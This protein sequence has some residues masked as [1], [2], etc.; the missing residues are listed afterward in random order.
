[1]TDV[2]TDISI[3]QRL[4]DLERKQAA[5]DRGAELLAALPAPPPLSPFSRYVT[6][7]QNERIRERHE[8]AQREGQERE[9]AAEREAER[10][11]A[12]L[13]SVQ[14][15]L[16]DLD[17]KIAVADKRI[18]EQ[19]RTLDALRLERERL[20]TPPPEEEAAKPV[21]G[22]KA[23]LGA[24]FGT[25]LFGGSV[26]AEHPPFKRATAAELADLPNG[27]PLPPGADDGWVQGQRIVKTKGRSR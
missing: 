9:A 22:L 1:M 7:R 24:L 19:Q 18:R 21:Q 25:D 4:A 12:Y 11:R 17:E 16:D 26:N 20:R 14:P 3:G 2:D 5:A 10:V 23:K 13:E 27:D 8:A 15:D 6:E